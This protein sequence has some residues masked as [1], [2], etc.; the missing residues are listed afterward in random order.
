MGV[1]S[2][3]NI[4]GTMALGADGREFVASLY[5]LAVEALGILGGLVGVAVPAFD[6][7]QFVGVGKLLRIHIAVAGRAVL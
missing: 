3:Q 1:G 5:S 7:G 4:V 2:P 6:F